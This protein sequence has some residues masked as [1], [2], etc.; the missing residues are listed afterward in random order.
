MKKTISF[1][2]SVL[3][4]TAFIP[5]P[6]V[7]AQNDTMVKEIYVYDDILVSN[8]DI[9]EGMPEKYFYPS[10][11]FT[12]YNIS[13]TGFDKKYV[14]SVTMYRFIPSGNGQKAGNKMQIFDVSSA[15]DNLTEV[16][17]PAIN[18]AGGFLSDSIVYEEIFAQDQETSC[19]DEIDITEYMTS[20][21][22]G[23]TLTFRTDF[24]KGSGNTF[25]PYAAL[26]LP[27][28]QA[29]MK[30]RA[31]IAVEYNTSA[32]IEAINNSTGTELEYLIT[33]YGELF[34][35][36]VQTYSSS[37]NKEN[38]NSLLSGKTF[39]TGEEIKNAIEPMLSSMYSS[40]LLNNV[41]DDYDKASY[42]FAAAENSVT[43]AYTLNI[44]NTDL[45]PKHIKSVRTKVY[46]TNIYNN[47]ENFIYALD[48]S[49]NV[50]GRGYFDGTKNKY[51]YIDITDYAKS[52]SKDLNIKF[53]GPSVA[54]TF[55]TSKS[56]NPPQ[57]EVYLDESSLINDFNSTDTADEFEKLFGDYGTVIGFDFEYVSQYKHKIAEALYSQ[58]FDDISSLKQAVNNC[59]A[60]LAEDVLNRM[61]KAETIDMFI[62]IIEKEYDMLGIDLSLYNTLS[63]DQKIYYTNTIFKQ[64]NSV[65]EF[66]D[67]FNQL[68]STAFELNTTVS[69]SEQMSEYISKHAEEL[70]LNTK[71]YD[72]IEYKENFNN[73]LL[74]GIPFK[75]ID[76]FCSVFNSEIEKRISHSFMTIPVQESSYDNTGLTDF[77]KWSNKIYKFNLSSKYFDSDYLI[78]ADLVLTRSAGDGARSGELI[79]YSADNSWTDSAENSILTDTSVVAGKISNCSVPAGKAEINVD[80]LD[81]LKQSN[82]KTISLRTAG[83][84]Q[85]YYNPTK[86]VSRT[87]NGA[88]IIIKADIAGII[89]AV[90][91]ADIN[92]ITDLIINNGHWLGI[93]VNAYMNANNKHEI[94][95]YL[96][97][98]KY[99]NANQFKQRFNEIINSMTYSVYVPCTADGG[100]SYN[101][102]LGSLSQELS[103]FYYNEFN[104]EE[105]KNDFILSVEAG[106]TKAQQN[107]EYSNTYLYGGTVTNGTFSP[108]DGILNDFVIGD[109]L[110]TYYEADITD[111]AKSESGTFAVGMLGDKFAYINRIKNA[112]YVKVTYDLLKIV[113]TIGS[114]NDSDSA[115]AMLETYS[116]ELSLYSDQQ[117]DTLSKLI[118][119]ITFTSLSDFLS[120]AKLAD[121]R[122]IGIADVTDTNVTLV[123][124]D[125]HDADNIVI[126]AAL[127]DENNLMTSILFVN[128][129]DTL[130]AGKTISIPYSINQTADNMQL[131]VFMWKGNEALTPIDTKSIDILSE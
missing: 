38:I 122:K 4:C 84:L 118:T 16:S 43:N 121:E 56:A 11:Y 66:K 62:S 119:G 82:D 73:I 126:A 15:L 129:I 39:S 67:T 17:Y 1:F 78:S 97:S 31:K 98:E 110:N 93:N 53:S 6:I 45:S 123:N 90:N 2:T 108:A 3:M 101:S 19:Y 34:G 128:T 79:V 131:R 27:N 59:S 115:K 7:S 95:K 60:V 57:I 26:I 103:A 105:Y 28:E 69:T 46:I 96:L 41:S 33:K 107:N 64:Y 51:Y 87:A 54:L 25:S 22:L 18:E 44:K 130:F 99:Q 70:K 109:E 74:N 76:T 52:H 68:F 92:S 13:T 35:I 42:S 77:S 71:I 117:I 83:N 12:T 81:F 113:N 36:D 30:Q 47:P 102:N 50:I 100:S 32:I 49:G 120:L 89:D 23:D 72:R 94:N 114:L 112:P 5:S 75:N 63:N 104:I 24:F 55:Q 48:K 58:K 116:K 10:N 111:Y 9:C 20:T 40:I 21:D 8:Q 65:D 125:S 80:I 85:G 14:S 29:N 124:C 37:V 91:N 106:Y 61:N 88:K 86:S 127:F